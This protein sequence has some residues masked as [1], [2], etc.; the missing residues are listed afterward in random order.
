MLGH[1]SF[2]PPYL[3]VFTTIKM[4]SLKDALLQ[5][6]GLLTARNTTNTTMLVSTDVVIIGGGASGSHAAV[7]LTD[8]GQD[9]IVIEKQSNLVRSI[10]S[11]TSHGSL[12]SHLDSQTL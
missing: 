1:A 5:T 12:K 9:V 8:Y 3:S 7:R 10:A 2:F 4:V 11:M 6:G